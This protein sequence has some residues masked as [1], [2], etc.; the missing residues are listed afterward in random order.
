MK[1]HRAALQRF[2]KKCAN[3]RTCG[4]RH[5]LLNN[6]YQS[7]MSTSKFPSIIRTINDQKLAFIAC[8][9]GTIFLL[10]CQRLEFELFQIGEEAAP[11]PLHLFEKVQP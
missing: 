3:E 4:D 2:S 8:F 11:Q 9:L 10:Y 1:S 7:K 6:A 5:P